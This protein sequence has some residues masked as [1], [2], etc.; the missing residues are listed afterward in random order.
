M[1]TKYKSYRIEIE[2]SEHTRFGTEYVAWISRGRSPAIT[3]KVGGSE[4]EALAAA[5]RWVNHNIAA[6]LRRDPKDKNRDAR[7]D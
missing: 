3:S 7:Q 6:F 5:V 2:T 4:A 1:I